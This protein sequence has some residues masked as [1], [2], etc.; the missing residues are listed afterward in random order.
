[1][2]SDEHEEFFDKTTTLRQLLL[3]QCSS[4]PV[5]EQ[6]KTT[7]LRQLLNDKDICSLITA[8]RGN[9]FGFDTIKYVFTARIRYFLTDRSYLGAVRKSEY[10]NENEI[11]SYITEIKQLGKKYYSL[12]YFDHIG[13]ALQVLDWY[14]MIDKWEYDILIELL[15]VTETYLISKKYKKLDIKRVRNVLNKLLIPKGD[16]K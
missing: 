15:N 13:Y 6:D 11:D 1:M 14:E 10:L 16:K 5:Q 8:L 9:D 3:L 4:F 12:H 2:I 7:T